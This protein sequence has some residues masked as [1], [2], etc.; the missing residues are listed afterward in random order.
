MISL[1]EFQLALLGLLR[2]VRFDAGFAGFF[3]LSRDGA[4]RSFRLALPL[5]PIIFFLMH[6]DAGW[7]DGTDMTRVVI[8]ELTG[9]VLGWVCFPL[10]LVHA[11]RAIERET[12]TYGAIAIYNW[13][14]VL[15]IGLQFPIVIAAHYGL[16]RGLANDLIWLVILFITACEF[17]AFWRLLGTG[18]GVIVA[19]VAADFSLSRILEL[20]TYALALGYL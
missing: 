15:S 4:R 6:L 19:L 10:L 17:F 2:L 13:L 16:D 20:G 3:D 9:Y 11:G 12:S 18:I 1:A 14:C 5:L 7:P 8:A